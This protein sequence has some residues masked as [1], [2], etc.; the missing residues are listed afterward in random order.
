MCKVTVQDA[1]A[2]LKDADRILIL[3]HQY[4]DGDTIGSGFAL[5]HA[6]QRLGKQA[7]VL[8]HDV[9]P[10]KY[11][12]MTSEVP[13]MDFEPAFICSVDVADQKLLGES[14]QEYVEHVE[15]SIDHHGSHRQFGKHLLLDAS[16]GAN[17]MIVLQ[18]I[19]QLGVE[20]DPLTANCLYTG[21]ATDTGCFKYSNT[22]PLTHRMAAQL[23][24]AG[25]K[26]E[27]IN[28]EMFDIKSRARV[29][30]EQMALQSM[31]FYDDGRCAFMSITEEMIAQS[32]AA[33]NDME[34]LSPMAR[35]IEGVWVGVLMR[36]KPD[37]TYKISVRTGTHADASA[38]C[39]LLG[40]GGHPRAAG[41][42]LTGTESAVVAQMLDAIHRAVP[43]LAEVR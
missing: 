6:L 1:A 23:M 20:I 37:G 38:I 43:R 8:C 39:G 4:P 29:K 35:Q 14:L 28:R 27:I 16:C 2:M 34:G 10:E 41:C 3:I 5:C 32:G 40:G 7:R 26:A 24:E 42:T 17:A 18:V 21:I 11:A 33:E 19:E 31:I 36:Q 25:A 13:Q 22:T 15:L 9:I 30:L 12:Y